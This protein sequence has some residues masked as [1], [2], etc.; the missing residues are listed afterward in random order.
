MIHDDVD[1]EDDDSDA[2]RAISHRAWDTP[3]SITL[4]VKGHIKLNSFP[5]G[6]TR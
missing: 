5:L 1:D 3:C 4:T 6:C 2:D